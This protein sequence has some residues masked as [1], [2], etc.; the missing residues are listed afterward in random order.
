MIE[1]DPAERLDVEALALPPVSG[2]LPSDVLPSK[3][4]TVPVA[5]D[6]ATVAVNVTFWPDVDGL[7]LEVTVV[8][9][10]G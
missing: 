6:G 8:V 2:A 3:N 10:P 7:R 9:D 5:D 4:C 1:W